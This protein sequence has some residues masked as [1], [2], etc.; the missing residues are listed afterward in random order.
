MRYIQWRRTKKNWGRANFKEKKNSYKKSK[1]PLNINV[2][3]C[4]IFS[5][6]T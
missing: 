2:L 6:I 3:Y 5:I 4:I 1:L